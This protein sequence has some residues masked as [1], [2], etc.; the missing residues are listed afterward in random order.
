M[1]IFGD[2]SQE[3]S[4][5]KLL[6]ADVP[7]ALK[8]SKS[9]NFYTPEY[10]N[11]VYER[12]LSVSGRPFTPKAFQYKLESVEDTL[13]NRKSSAL[14]D[15]DICFILG[16]RMAQFLKGDRVVLDRE[17]VIALEHMFEQYG[18]LHLRILG[19]TY[20]TWRD[21][22]ESTSIRSISSAPMGIEFGM[23]ISYV[24]KKSAR[25]V[26]RGKMIF[27][28]DLWGFHPV[29]FLPSNLIRN[30]S[31]DEGVIGLNRVLADRHLRRKMAQDYIG[32][33]TSKVISKDT[34]QEA[35]EIILPFV[36]KSEKHDP[37]VFDPLCGGATPADTYLVFVSSNSKLDSVRIK[38]IRCR[39]C[40]V[41]LE[42]KHVLAVTDNQ[43]RTTKGT[44]RLHTAIEK[45]SLVLSRAHGSTG[46]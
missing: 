40:G 19:K 31:L 43:V 5:S 9:Q 6:T 2:P 3:L 4:A 13:V 25:H 28:E 10:Y 12:L 18:V 39:V 45:A 44:L 11:R 32:R 26:I 46:C 41:P 30:Y 23:K 21:F 20:N 14:K 34:F 16:Q 17:A 22:A 8:V 15:P 1:Y 33:P 36:P 42:M 27:T 24:D 37:S 7:R 29:S 35:M 38:V